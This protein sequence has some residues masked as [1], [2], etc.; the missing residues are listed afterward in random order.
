MAGKRAVCCLQ[1]PLPAGAA[2]GC[3]RCG[4]GP[5]D[6]PPPPTAHGGGGL[7]G[8]GLG[9]LG[10]AAALLQQDPSLRSSVVTLHVTPPL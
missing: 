9:A 10:A 8:G 6:C 2:A 3:G 1:G 7:P 4:L 5:L